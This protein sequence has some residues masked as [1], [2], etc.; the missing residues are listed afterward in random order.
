MQ[1]ICVQIIC[2]LLILI[3]YMLGKKK[4]AIALCITILFLCYVQAIDPFFKSSFEGKI[5]LEHAKIISVQNTEKSIRYEVVFQHKTILKQQI[6]VSTP[7]DD[8]ALE[9]G[10]GLRGRCVLKEIQAPVNLGLFDYKLY[11]KSQGIRFQCYMDKI[12]KIDLPGY[13][14]FQLKIR[15][16][17][18]IYF[19]LFTS[20]VEAY[21]QAFILGDTSFFGE[22]RQIFIELGL[23]HILAISGAHLEAIQLFFLWTAKKIRMT[24]EIAIFLYLGFIIIYSGVLKRSISFERALIM[25]VSMQVLEDI[26]GARVEPEQKYTLLFLVCSYLIIRNP[27]VIYN[28]AFQYSVLCSVFLT[29]YANKGYE[30]EGRVHKYIWYAKCNICCILITLPL[31]IAIQQQFYLFTLISTLIFRAFLGIVAIF[32]FLTALIPFFEAILVQILSILNWMLIFSQKLNYNISIPLYFQS[33]QLVLTCCCIVNAHNLL[34]SRRA[35]KSLFAV[36]TLFILICMV[37]FNLQLN[38]IHFLS[39]PHGEATVIKIDGIIYMIDTGGGMRDL[40]N[41]AIAEKYLKPFMLKNGM[42]KINHL[43]LTHDDID[44]VGAIFALLTIVTVDKIYL[45]ESSNTYYEQL[46]REHPEVEVEIVTDP[47]KLPHL[48]IFSVLDT[49]TNNND[50]SLLVY[51]YFGRMYW[52]F[53]GDLEKEGEKALIRQYPKL[54]VDVIKVGHHGS[55]TSTSR[56]LLAAYKPEYGIINVQ[57]KNIHNH[58]SKEVVDRLDAYNIKYW[59]TAVDG[60]QS[61]FFIGPFQFFLH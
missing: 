16:A 14:V 41:I 15:R 44:H 55:K 46:K 28:I 35:I 3:V 56:E 29:L 32:S 34:S 45:N 10:D 23:A 53:L 57:T 40:D 60:G 54:R 13:Q 31:V 19:T 50:T 17:L 42:G 38:S 39:L 6:Y 5:T 27:F 11:T 33:Q 4:G 9:V 7:P 8:K 52:L 47:K 49:S 59:V 43:I 18:S 51:G 58:P 26:Q 22:N 20:E 21:L 24:K 48:V 36:F 25:R 12:E 30:I 61:Y 37:Q 1:I 2:Y